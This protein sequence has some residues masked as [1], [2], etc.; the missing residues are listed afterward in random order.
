MT[1]MMSPNQRIRQLERNAGIERSESEYEEI[2]KAYPSQPASGSSGA[3]SSGST[4]YRGSTVI[5]KT[6]MAQL[7]SPADNSLKTTLG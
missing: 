2:E 6:G 1:A 5:K 7:L 4:P 3:A